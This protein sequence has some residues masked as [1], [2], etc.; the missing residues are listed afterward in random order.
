M[1]YA[2][3]AETEEEAAEPQADFERRRAEHEEEQ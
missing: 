2:P 3:E 1:A